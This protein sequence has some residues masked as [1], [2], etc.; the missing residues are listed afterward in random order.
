VLGLAGYAAV[1]VSLSNSWFVGVNDD[2]NVA[3][4][5]GIPEEIA[6]LNLKEEQEETTIVA[7]ELPEFIRSRLEE[8]IKVGS[9]EEAESTV[10]NFENLVQEPERRTRARTNDR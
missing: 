1:R 4:Y 9:P 5:Q 10:E 2:G 3:I 8:G 7:A 6:G